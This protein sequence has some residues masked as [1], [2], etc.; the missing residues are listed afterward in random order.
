MRLA[1][2][3]DTWPRQPFTLL[4][5]G[6]MSVTVVD[7]ALECAIA[8]DAPIVFIPSRN[9]VE[10][11][12][13]YVEGWTSW[14]FRRHVRQR[15]ESYRYD[16]L[17]YVGRDHGGP[18][19]RDQEYV[20]RIDWEAALGS[21]LASYQQDIEAGFDYLHI[22]TARDPHL[23]GDVP[24]DLAA[25]R[26]VTVLEKIEA[27]RRDAGYPEVDY[28]VSLEQANGGSSDL[29]DFEYFLGT[30]LERIDRRGLPR[31]LFVVGNTGTLTKAGHNVGTVDFQVISGLADLAERHQVVLKEHNADYLSDDVLALHP[32]SRVGMANVAPEF[33]KLETESL[34]QLA[35]LEEAACRRRGLEPSG[36]ERILT[37]QVLRSGRW[38]KW[39]PAGADPDTWL[40]APELR[41]TLVAGSGHYCFSDESVRRASA[42]LFRNCLQ[43]GVCRSP[44]TF[45]K[46]VLNRGLQRYLF[47]FGL[48]G[49]NHDLAA[50]AV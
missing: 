11:T 23:G 22:D 40:H 39:L 26:A 48:A 19:Q 38:R 15:M 42:Q 5:I 46:D 29:R 10:T 25:E 9:Q 18:W 28:E 13:G 34:L 1:K 49:L 6:P 47:A 21:A 7:V 33:G 41:R 30:L 36:F 37:D 2:L 31:P 24:L 44:S 14:T 8:H 16:G 35:A 3:F 43:L 12:G 45:V 20:A 32:A 27:F 50:A 17:V 4:G